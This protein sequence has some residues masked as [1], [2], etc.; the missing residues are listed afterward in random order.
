MGCR[1][2]GWSDGRAIRFDQAVELKSSRARVS[3]AREA[4]DGAVSPGLNYDAGRR[5]DR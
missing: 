3:I 4:L 5:G 1:R 2:R